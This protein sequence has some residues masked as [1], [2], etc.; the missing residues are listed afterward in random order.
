MTRSSQCLVISL[1]LVIAVLL[2]LLFPAYGR[3]E[4]INAKQPYEMV[5]TLQ[6]LQ[7]KVAEGNSHAL[8]TQRALLLQMDT[9][10]QVLPRAMWQDPRNARAAVVHLLSGGHPGIVKLLLTYD[11]APA[12]DE[13]LMLGALAYVEGREEDVLTHF[14]LIDPRDLPPSLGGHVALVKA[15]VLVNKDPQQALELL[16]I[17]RLLM[18]G[19]LV[20]EAALRREVFVAGK[21]GA[22]ERFQSLSLRY[23]RRFRG[24]IYAGDFVRRFTLALDT[25]GFGKQNEKFVLLES[26]LA[27]FNEDTRRTL[28]LRLARTAILH[29]QRDIV[30]KATDRAMPLAMPGSHE[31]ALF[32]LYRAGALVGIEDIKQARDMLWSIDQNLLAPQEKE[33]MRAVYHVLNSVRDWPH[34]PA[35]IIGEFSIYEPMQTPKGPDWTRP[36]MQKAERLI[37]QSAVLLTEA[38]S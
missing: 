6:S 12:I 36:V 21:A 14:G 3:A 27:E 23:L 17:A 11:P 38:G 2:A 13:N 37:E 33:L 19:T 7:A 1:A 35:G 25:L 29:G 16:G 5:R 4:D 15:A 32:K 8:K 28:Y 20:E 24:S 31:E 10:F 9:F 18:P 22:I 34:P 30:E 26:L